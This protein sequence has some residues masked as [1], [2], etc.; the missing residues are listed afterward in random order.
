[1]FQFHHFDRIW[2]AM[3]I[4]IFE[5]TNLTF[6]QESTE[7]NHDQSRF[8]ILPQTT[9]G[10]QLK[11]SWMNDKKRNIKTIR[12]L[13]P[14]TPPPSQYNNG[15]IE[16]QYIFLLRSF[17]IQMPQNPEIVNTVFRCVPNNFLCSMIIIIIGW[18]CAFFEHFNIPSA[19]VIE[20]NSDNLY[21]KSNEIWNGI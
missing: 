3:K 19:I 10:S 9:Q 12:N 21:S 18:N 8:S 15:T 1:M 11:R 16:I 17:N 14:H 20:L 2:K 4:I 6:Y 13:K 7:S 5:Y